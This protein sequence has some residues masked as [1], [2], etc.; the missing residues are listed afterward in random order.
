MKI[1]AASTNNNGSSAHRKATS[2]I[3]PRQTSN[4]NSKIAMDQH[5]NDSGKQTLNQTSKKSDKL[6]LENNQNQKYALMGN[7]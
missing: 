3:V 2:V 7:S 6:L 4:S 1:I 5:L